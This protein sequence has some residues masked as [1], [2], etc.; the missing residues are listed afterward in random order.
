MEIERLRQKDI[1]Y[2]HQC[3]EMGENRGCPFLHVMDGVW[4]IGFR[5]CHMKMR[6]RIND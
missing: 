5:H 1:M 4:K 3:S 6:V 2:S